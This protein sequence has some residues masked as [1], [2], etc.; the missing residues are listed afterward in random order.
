LE[1]AQDRARRATARSFRDR[2]VVGQA[3]NTLARRATIDAI[4]NISQRASQYR[5]LSGNRESENLRNLIRS[6]EIRHCIS[7]EHRPRRRPTE[8]E[9]HIATFNRKVK[10]GPDQICLYCKQINKLSRAYLEEHC[11]CREEIY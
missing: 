10:L 1:R 2:R 4:Q 3:R 7:Q 9:V 11:E 6:Q 8:L 5:S